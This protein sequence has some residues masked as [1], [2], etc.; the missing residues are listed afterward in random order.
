MSGVGFHDGFNSGFMAIDAE[1]LA[2]RTFRKITLP[3]WIERISVRLD[4][5]MPLD[6]D[7]SGPEHFQLDGFSLQRLSSSVRRK[8]PVVPADEM[9]VSLFRPPT[10][11]S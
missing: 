1:L 4:F 10:G 8:Y 2:K 9:E 11:F 3:V 5:D 7:C 6:S